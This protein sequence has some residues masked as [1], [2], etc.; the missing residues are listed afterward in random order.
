MAVESIEILLDRALR[1]REHLEDSRHENALRLFN[2]FLEGCP[3]LAV[4]LYAATAVLHDYARDAKRGRALADAA[5]ELLHDRFP[6]LRAIILKRRYGSSTEAKRGRLVLGELLDQ[7]VCEDGV[8][9][10]VD[11][12]RSQDASLYLDTRELRRWARQNLKDKTV[13]NTFAYTGS[14]GVAARAGGARRVV[15]IDRNRNSLNLAKASNTFN[16]FSLSAQDFLAGDFFPLVSTLKRAGEFFDCVF[17]DP[18]FFSET[19]KGTVDLAKNCARLINKVRPLIADGGRLVAVNNALYVSGRAY[20]ETLQTLCADGYLKIEELVP[21]P[22]DFTGF[23]ETRRGSPVTDPA[24][25]N[26]ST[27]IAVLGVRRKGE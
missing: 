14:L 19:A 11:L 25:F 5:V 6:W 13:L 7:R 24:P 15:Q 22:E 26:H 21:V 8:W 2:G 3:D 17:L 12:V 4:D 9:Y 23:P 1:A 18:P 10:A 20:M 27:K 16:G